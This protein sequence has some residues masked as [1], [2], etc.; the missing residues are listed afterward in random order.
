MKKIFLLGAF[1]FTG[2]HLFAQN[3]F[4]SAGYS[5]SR[6]AKSYFYDPYGTNVTLSHDVYLFKS[7]FKLIN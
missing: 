3:T 2:T 7:K 6:L 1:L 5:S 4:I